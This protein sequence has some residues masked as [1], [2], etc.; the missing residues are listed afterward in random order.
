MSLVGY[1]NGIDSW[2]LCPGTGANDPVQVSKDRE[3]DQASNS[4]PNTIL[5]AAGRR[6]A[7]GVDDARTVDKGTIF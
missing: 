3:E 5:L 7:V 4:P 6:G 1:K 2:Y